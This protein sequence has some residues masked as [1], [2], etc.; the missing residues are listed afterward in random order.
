MRKEL[1]K[2]KELLVIA[3]NEAQIHGQ[4]VRVR[5]LKEEINSLLD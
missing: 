3:E 2:K 5:A 1:A 4:N